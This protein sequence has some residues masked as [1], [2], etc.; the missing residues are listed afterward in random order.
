MKALIIR[1]SSFGDILQCMAA[2]NWLKSQSP[3]TTID[4]IT[5][6]DSYELL[7]MSPNV[8]HVYA[9]KREQGL[10]GLIGLAK[11]L[12]THNYDIIYDAHNNLRSHIFVWSYRFFSTHKFQFLRRSKD[13]FKRFLLFKL[14]INLFP[15]PYKGAHSYLSPLKKIGHSPKF[16]PTP[17]NAK[18]YNKPF[19][20]YICLAPSAAWEM[21]RWPIEYWRQ[22][23]ELMP[24]ENFV[25]LGGPKD[26]FLESILSNPD[27]KKR[28]V[29][30]AGK[31]SWPET[32]KLIQNSKLLI[33]NDTGS[34][35]LA[36][37]QGVPCIALMGPTA[38]G[39]P[40]GEQSKTL[41]TGLS[42]QPCSKDGR[43]KCKQKTY[44]LCLYQLTPHIVQNVVKDIINA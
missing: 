20:S 34:L 21:K 22:L 42:C 28:C 33:S 30:L 11:Q 43:G 26:Q 6:Q 15:T 4:W 14:R 9:F 17:L 19:E 12:S 36:D 29:N 23:I 2:A 44:K 1:F 18:D 39:T 10:R 31:L 5:R 37:L 27:L 7:N 13:R 25:I 3:N 8:D 35:H 38:F 32:T 40:S 24:E 41:S 16:L